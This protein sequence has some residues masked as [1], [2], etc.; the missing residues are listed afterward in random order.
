MDQKPKAALDTLKKGV[1]LGEK[2]INTLEEYVN[3]LESRLQSKN[4]DGPRNIQ[5]FYPKTVE[6]EY[7]NKLFIR[8]MNNF[9]FAELEH[10][11]KLGKNCFDKHKNYKDH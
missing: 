6:D 2:A 5:A 8:L 10:M 1:E 9:T 4:Y 11:E 7:R 3:E